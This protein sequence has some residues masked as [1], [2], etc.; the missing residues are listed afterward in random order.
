M[1]ERK[2][3]PIEAMR[4]SVVFGALRKASRFWPPSVEALK[5]SEVTGSKPKKYL[6]A[7]CKKEFARDGVHRDH[8][9]PV[10][11]PATGFSGWDVYIPRLLCPVDGYQVLCVGCHD[12]KTQGENKQR[13]KRK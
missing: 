5:A 2:S 1:K 13:R 12:E 4:R 11:D 9:N 7:A 10:V 3:K 6:C 8:K